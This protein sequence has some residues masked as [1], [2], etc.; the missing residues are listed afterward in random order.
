MYNQCVLHVSSIMSSQ[1][2]ALDFGEL[3]H[4]I[5]FLIIS[6]LAMVSSRFDHL[7]IIFTKRIYI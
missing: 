4:A 6:L 1:N 5:L 7:K 3:A 2:E